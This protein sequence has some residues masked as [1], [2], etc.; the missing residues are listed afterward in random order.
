MWIYSLGSNVYCFANAVISCIQGK[1]D[2]FPTAHGFCF[3]ISC[4]EGCETSQTLPD[5]H[6]GAGIITDKFSKLGYAVYHLKNPTKVELM[7]AFHVL[8]E[9]ISFPDSYK[10][11]FILFTGHGT[12]DYISTEDGYI[13]CNDITTLFWP[14]AAD[15]LSAIPKIFLF[16]CCRGN[17][18]GQS[19][20]VERQAYLL[21]S[22][23]SERRAN[24][25]CQGNILTMFSAPPRCR[26]WSENGI[27]FATAELAELLDQQKPRSLLDLLMVDL[28]KRVKEATKDYPECVEMHPMV[29]GCLEQSIDLYMDKVNASKLSLTL[30]LE[31]QQV[32]TQIYILLTWDLAPPS[33]VSSV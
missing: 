13:S 21:S 11:I 3:A 28:W 10:N 32:Y 22:K 5:I 30:C 19:S 12:E 25:P 24:R 27:G 31:S 7:A 1:I 4:E 33:H 23:M 14:C 17:I 6:K 29:E 18:D 2:G 20:D 16:D 9:D 8:A 26:A 15:K